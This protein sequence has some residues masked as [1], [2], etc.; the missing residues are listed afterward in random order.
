M[1]TPCDAPGKKK[2]RSRIAQAIGITSYLVAGFLDVPGWALIPLIALGISAF[3]FDA[4][5]TVKSGKAHK[6][7][8]QKQPDYADPYKGSPPYP[9]LKE[10]VAVSIGFCSF[11]LVA[12]L[13]LPMRDRDLSTNDW[14]VL[15]PLLLMIAG[16]GYARR[17][18]TKY[19]VAHT[20]WREA[21]HVPDRQLAD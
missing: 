5:L 9:H 4:L 1:S 15:V 8:L 12:Y 18:H 20:S 6:E 7:W 14:W 19:A 21:Q 16:F 13:A 17:V 11:M 3:L 10:G 2:T